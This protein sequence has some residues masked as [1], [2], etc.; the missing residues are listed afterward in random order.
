MNTKFIISL[1]ALLLLLTFFLMLFL[2]LNPSISDEDFDLEYKVLNKKKAYYEDRNHSFKDQNY[3]F[4]NN[5]YCNNE[6]NYKLTIHSLNIVKEKERIIFVLENLSEKTIESVRIDYLIENNE[7]LNF[8][9]KL[10]GD[11][12]YLWDKEKQLFFIGKKCR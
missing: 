9:I 6:K 2:Y 5:L 12:I 3:T 4:N 8:N 1:G 7:F 11:S 10:N